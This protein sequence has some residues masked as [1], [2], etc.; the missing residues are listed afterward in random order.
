MFC[1]A[2]LPATARTQNLR[3]A[4]F[5]CG[6]QELSRPVGGMRN[7]NWNLPPSIV[8]FASKRWINGNKPRISGSFDQTRQWHVDCIT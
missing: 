5:L 1:I 8:F 4:Q 6:A 3:F 2:V 7:S